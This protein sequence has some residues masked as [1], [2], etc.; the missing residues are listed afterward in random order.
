M[1][2]RLT[3]AEIYT[4]LVQGGFTPDQ[5]RTMTAI[6][7]AESGGNPGAV[8][9][10]GLQ[11]ATWGPSVGLF[12]VRTLKDD[13]GRGTARDITHL[14]D[15][16]RAQVQAALKISDHGRNLQPWS[17]YTSGSYRRFLNQSLPEHVPAADVTPTVDPFSI[18]AGRKPIA[19]TDE[20]HDGLM[21]RFED[22]FGTDPTQ[23]DTDHDGRTD[24]QETAADH[25][26]PLNPDTDHDGR[27]DGEEQ[28]GHTSAGHADLPA[29]AVKAGFG[30]QKNL[31]SDQDGLSDWHEGQHGT[32]PHRRDSDGDGLNDGTEESGG[33]DPGKLDSNNDGLDDGFSVQ[34]GLP[35][36]D[37]PLDIDLDPAH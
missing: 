11:N 5:A 1:T 22:L 2:R 31:D 26:D 29:A 3:A 36:V 13:T 32:D 23:A 24:T 25:T 8:G 6:A 21:K 17:T 16:V 28:A 30:G 37:Q 19:D 34:H 4:L 33:T 15:D 12:Q 10:V 20:D 9:D 18:D 14:S 7:Q 27:K 35:A